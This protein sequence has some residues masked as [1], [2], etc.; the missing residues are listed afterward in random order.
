MKN[1][2]AQLNRFYNA[3]APG[4]MA[5]SRG[6]ALGLALLLALNLIEV[7]TLGTNSVQNWFCSFSPLNQTASTAILAIAVPSLLLF[8][9]RPALPGPVQLATMG[10]L[11]TLGGFCAWRILV[12]Q[13][14]LPEVDR[15]TAM[16]KPFGLMLICAVAGFGV[17]AGNS[18][19][20]RGRSSLLAILFASTIS[21][22]AF[23]V[24]SIQSGGVSDTNSQK[25]LPIV[26]VTS[27]PAESDGSISEALKDRIETAARLVT[28]GWAKKLLICSSAAAE[29]SVTAAALAEAAIA[30]GV[31]EADVI[32]N[33]DGTSP[34]AALEAADAVGLGEERQLAFVSHWHELATIRLLASRRKLDVVAIPAKQSHA[35]FGQNMLVVKEVVRLGKLFVAPVIQ[36]AKSVQNGNQPESKEEAEPEKAADDEMEFPEFNE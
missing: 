19:H 1:D 35:L 33:S 10:T 36:Y 22:L 27:L 8:A 3:P 31:P 30:A 2:R 23:L 34:E 32:Q 11:L 29:E 18:V 24:V 15:A 6:A 14:Q 26:V 12:I 21:V 13:K 5:V 4:W 7:L 17:I 9:M 25:A 20:V 16:L 28:D